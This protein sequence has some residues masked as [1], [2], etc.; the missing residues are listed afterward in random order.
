M[1][2]GLEDLN[3][4]GAETIIYRFKRNDVKQDEVYIQLELIF[5]EDSQR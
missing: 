5:E 3:L 4:P 2:V 1:F